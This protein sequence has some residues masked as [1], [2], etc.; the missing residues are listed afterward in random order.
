M[1]ARHVGV[2]VPILE[3]RAFLLHRLMPTKRPSY[4]SIQAEAVNSAVRNLGAPSEGF[5]PVQRPLG[6][7]QMRRAKCSE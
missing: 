4:A 2:T 5:S 3:G 6:I 7:L 1:T